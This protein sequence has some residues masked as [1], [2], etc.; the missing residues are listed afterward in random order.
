MLPWHSEAWKKLLLTSCLAQGVCLFYRVRIAGHDWGAVLTWYMAGM[1]PQR[2][3]KVAVLSCGHA[4]SFFP[5]GG[6][7]QRQLSWYMLFFVNPEAEEL[8]QANDWALWKVVIGEPESDF[9]RS[10]ISQM[11][12]E[13]ALTAG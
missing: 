10:Q 12:K 7:K 1:N 3:H 6:L 4:M 8:L 5:Q 13:G 11:A 2:F 9:S